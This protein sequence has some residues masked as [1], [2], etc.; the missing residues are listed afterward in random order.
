M[1]AAT[2]VQ[3][4]VASTVT[5]IEEGNITPEDVAQLRNI[6]RYNREAIPLLDR[7]FLNGSASAPPPSRT[8]LVRYIGMV[9]DM[10][11]TEYYLCE[12]NGVKTHYRDVHVTEK[13]QDNGMD[14]AHKLADRQ[15]LVMVP[16]PFA[17]E[18]TLSEWTAT[19]SSTRATNLGLDDRS[20]HKRERE[21]L[22]DPPTKRTALSTPDTSMDDS[23]EEAPAGN[24]SPSQLHTSH[25]E[26]VTSNSDWWPAGCMESDRNQCAVLAKLYYD[27]DTSPRLRLNEVVELVGV[28]SMDPLD[29]Q[30]PQASDE[31]N[32]FDEFSNVNLPPPS[33][34][35][36][37]H[38]LC[39]NRLNL[40]AG[41][42]ADTMDVAATHKDDDR[43]LAIQVFAKHIFGGNQVAAE[44]LLMALMSMAERKLVSENTWTPIKTPSETTLGTASLNL[45][46]SSEASCAHMYNNL[47]KVLKKILPIVG[48]I[49]LTRESL[50]GTLA[51]PAKSESGRLEPSPIQL[52]KGAALIINQSSLAEGRIEAHAVETLH[53]LN[54][55]T[56]NHSVPYRFGQMMYTFEADY[57][58]I[59]LSSATGGSE[60]KVAQGSKLLPCSMEMKLSDEMLTDDSVPTV[61]EDAC[62]RIRSY[63][64]RCRCST[65]SDRQDE[66]FNVQLP[67][68]VLELAQ[69]D[70]IERR[71][72]QRQKTEQRK[73]M[74][75]IAVGNSAQQLEPLAAA[76]GE[77]DFHR[78]LT[79][80]RLEE[81]SRI[82]FSDRGAS[83]GPE[84]ETWRAALALDDAMRS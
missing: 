14:I 40:E 70:F 63:L 6:V 31:W 21:D 45:I 27:Q 43:S 76:L 7:V 60:Q 32:D 20:Q 47:Q 68:T 3:A 33:L 79:I 67:A 72:D 38:V 73:R 75:A 77:D 58:V 64:T 41:R 44:A 8:V 66:V 30:F 83:E 5:K 46:L 28:L 53:A 12:V 29:V 23:M 65:P 84:N 37:L 55:L 54:S 82:P 50:G 51:S 36:R 57:R 17:S 9:Q 42:N 34:L 81:R 74:Q 25:S 13:P 78:W 18:W 10:L 24:N 61:P 35:P 56:R 49:E 19:P 48:S 62:Q 1:T 22:M 69:K 59:V 15:P 4:T 16:I 52:P 39:Y 80:A 11:E 26:V 71:A 2:E